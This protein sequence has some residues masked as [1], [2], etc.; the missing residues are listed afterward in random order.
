[1][2]DSHS[3]GL[4]E[5]LAHHAC[6]FELLCDV[7]EKKLAELKIRGHL[8]KD[9]NYERPVMDVGGVED[10]L[11]ENLSKYKQQQHILHHYES[12]MYMFQQWQSCTSAIN[13]RN[14]ILV[15]EQ[16]HKSFKL[17]QYTNERSDKCYRYSIQP[18]SLNCIVELN[19]HLLKNARD[20]CHTLL[21]NLDVAIHL[22]ISNEPLLQP[23]NIMQLI[24]TTLKHVPRYLFH[25]KNIKHYY[26]TILEY[27][28]HVPFWEPTDKSIP[29]Y[30][31][32]TGL[33][34]ENE[35][36]NDRTDIYRGKCPYSLQRTT[37]WRELL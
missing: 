14:E 30:A 16:K 37:N 33:I 3:S 8:W 1:M 36:Y 19:I 9:G 10:E 28:A 6:M 25:K 23:R 7:R 2:N 27:V 4:Q 17:K 32:V 13:Y 15:R 22:Q 5:L 12:L 24:L 11:V 29:D 34:H 18:D 26:S 21:N 20:V 35:I 31:C